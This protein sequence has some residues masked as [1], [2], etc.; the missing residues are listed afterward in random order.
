MK[1]SLAADPALCV[2]APRACT[3]ALFFAAQTALGVVCHFKLVQA[4]RA[5]RMWRVVLPVC[6]CRC[7]QQL[8]AGVC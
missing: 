6:R 3:P 7:C 1:G 5:V 4:L 2:A 8:G